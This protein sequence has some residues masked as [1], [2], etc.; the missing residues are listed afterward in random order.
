MLRFV[1]WICSNNCIHWWQYS[2]I[3][4]FTSMYQ[5]CVRWMLSRNLVIKKS[6]FKTNDIIICWTWNCLKSESVCNIT[7]KLCVFRVLFFY[8]CDRFSMSMNVIVY[9]LYVSTPTCYFKY[10]CYIRKYLDGISGILSKGFDVKASTTINQRKNKQ[11]HWPAS[12][13]TKGFRFESLLI[14]TL[15]DWL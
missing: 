13:K 2:Y 6:H 14:N 10:I 15:I 5:I 11:T 7:L 1:L 4:T 12:S 9:M 3:Y 8:F